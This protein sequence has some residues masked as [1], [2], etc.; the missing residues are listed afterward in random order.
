M[1][2]MSYTLFL[3]G[4][5]GRLNWNRG[6]HN[7]FIDSLAF[8][9]IKHCKN[10]KLADRRTIYNKTFEIGMDIIAKIHT[11]VTNCAMR[12]V[13]TGVACP[14]SLPINNVKYHEVGKPL[15]VDAIGYRFVLD[16]ASNQN[17]SLTRDNAKWADPS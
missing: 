7:T 10:D 2:L 1:D 6:D 12:Q 8:M 14:F 3:E 17:L 13:P 4:H 16:I 15:F 5:E 9:V 11:D